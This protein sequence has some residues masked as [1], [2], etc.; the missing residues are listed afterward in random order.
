MHCACPANCRTRN[1]ATQDID[2]TFVSAIFGRHLTTCERDQETGVAAFKKRIRFLVAGAE[3]ARSE[4]T[5]HYISGDV[6]W[7]CQGRRK[8]IP[9][10]SFSTRLC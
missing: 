7:R 8:S 2:P 4:C 1:G 5:P 6:A 9:L 3:K 10:A